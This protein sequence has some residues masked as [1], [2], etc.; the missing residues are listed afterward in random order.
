MDALHNKQDGVTRCNL[1]MAQN[2]QNLT[3][4]VLY[5]PYSLVLIGARGILIGARGALSNL[6]IPEKGFEFRSRQ[7]LLG[8][9]PACRRLIRPQ[10]CGCRCL[11]LQLEYATLELGAEGAFHVESSVRF[12][13]PPPQHIRRCMG[14]WDEGME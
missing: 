1:E 9:P 6:Q 3:V 13:Q 2:P 5:V 7:H 12:L 14:A 10:A 4:S 11:C 8:V